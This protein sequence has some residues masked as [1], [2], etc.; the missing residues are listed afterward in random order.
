MTDIMKK[1]SIPQETVISQS[2]SELI[3]KVTIPADSDYFDGHFPDFKLLPA[4]A[5]V[6]LTAHFAARYFGISPAMSNIKRFKF[7][8]KI[9]PD[10]TVIFKIS[11][12]DGKVAFELFSED[13][14]V[15][16]SSGTYTP[17]SQEQ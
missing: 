11:Y 8:D 5:Q 12:K 4:V 7:S 6:D 13:E 15:S 9:L 14:K 1:H 17:W 2:D 16:Y 10:S 3:L